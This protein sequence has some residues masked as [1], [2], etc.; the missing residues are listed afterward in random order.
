MSVVKPVHS[1]GRAASILVGSLLILALLEARVSAKPPEADA[2]ARAKARPVL[3]KFQQSPA[4]FIENRG[5][6]EDASIRFA[7]N[8]TGANAGLT[9]QGV[10]FQLFQREWVSSH[11]EP[12]R[13]GEQNLPS[14]LCGSASLREAADH[15]AVRNAV[16]KMKE[17]AICFDGARAV[18]PAGEGKSEQVFHYRRG[19]QAY[20]RENVPSWNAAV[21][22][23]L[24]EGIDLRVTGRRTGVKYEFLVSPGAD[25]RKI[26]LRYEGIEDLKLCEDGSLELKLGEGWRPLV[27][28]A[29]YIYQETAG[30]RKQVPGRFSLAGNR[31]C[32]F[33]IT[34]PLDP[35]LPL[36]IDPELAWSTYL[37]GSGDDGGWAGIAV[38][39]AGN[40]FVTGNTNSSGW[41]SGGYNTTFSG[42]ADAFVVKLSGSGAHLWSTYL[43]GSGDDYGCGIAADGVGNVFVSGTTGSSGWVSGGWDTTY[44]G[45]YCNAFVVK[46]SGSGEHLWSTYLGGGGDFVDFG[47]A[48]D[49]AGNVFV[50]GDTMSSGW[51]SG[52]GDTT[53]NGG[54]DAFVV[55]LSGEGVHLWSTYVGGS[56]ADGGNDIAVDNAG[57]VF[58]TGN[59][60]SSGWVSGGFDTTFH[61]GGSLPMDAYVAKLS[62]SGVHLWSTYLGGS[63]D[64]NGY[65][66][67]TDGA[68]NVFVTGYTMSSGWVS[69]GFDTTLGGSGDAFV[70]KLSESGSHLWSTYLGGSSDETGCGIAVDGAGNAFVT[71]GTRSSDWV[72]GGFDTTL[73]GSVDAFLAKL[74][75]NGAHLWS[76]Y[77]GGSSGDYGYAI[78][79]DGAGNVLVMG[80]TG[81][82][83]WVSGG[84]DTTYNGGQLDAFVAKIIDSG[85]LL[86]GSLRVTIAPPEC[87]AAGAQWRREG[88]T[89]WLD[90][91]YTESG[92]LV[93]N[94][95]V[96]FRDI[97]GWSTPGEMK[98][99]ISDGQTTNAS[100]IYQLFGCSLVWSTYLGGDSYDCGYGIAVDGTGNM[101]V[102]GCT[103][104]SG[105]VS[106]G[107]DTTFNGN[108]DA[109]VVKLSESGSHLWST[110]LGGDAADYGYGIAVDGTGNVFVTGYTNSSGWVSGGF[111]T[112]FN[113]GV[114][115]AFVVK[116]SGSGA[117]L[118][119]TYLGGS[120]EDYGYGIAVDGAGNVFVT[121]RTLSSGW[122]S[123]GFDTTYNGGF[124]DADD[125]DAFVAKL[126]GTGAHLWSTYLGGSDS[127]G[128]NAIA[129]DGAGNVLVTGN[130]SS[131]GWVLGGFDTTLDGTSDA[132][133][134]KLSGS[135]SH[136]WSTYLGG[137][138]YDC[139]Y[140]IAVDGAGN[141]F[142]TGMTNSSGWVSGGFDMTFNG[143]TDAFVAELSGSGEHLWSTYLG[144]SNPDYGNGIAVDGAGNVLVMGGTGSSGWVSGGFDTRLDGGFDAFVAELSGSGSH[145]WST[146]LG[147]ND[148]DW[149]NG[150]AVDSAGNVFVTGYTGSSD[151]VSGGFDTTYNGNSDAFVAKIAVIPDLTPPVILE[152]PL[153]TLITNQSSAIEWRT[154]EPATSFVYYGT[155]TDLGTI[156][157]EPGFASQHRVELTSL[158]ANTLY[159]YKVASSDAAGNGPTES[160]VF[161]F[162]TL[163]SPDLD[164]PEIT[165]G[166]MALDVTD[167]G[168]TILWTTN[169]V[170]TSGVSY[171]D[172]SAYGVVNDD[173]LVIQ[174]SMRL[175]NLT[176]ATL[177]YCTVSSKDAAGNGP[178]FSPEF[179]FTTQAT[180]DTA[181]PIITEGPIVMNVSSR[182][183]TARWITDE[184]ADSVVEYGLTTETLGQRVSRAPLVHQHNV[185]LT[186]L[187]T[188]TLY[189]Y[190]VLSTDVRGNGPT[191]SAV[192]SF[193]T[194]T[195]PDSL[196]P[197]F[198]DGPRVL[199]VNQSSATI[200]WETDEL[201]DTV[202]DYGEGLAL[203][204]RCSDSTKT[205]IHQITLT[206]LTGGQSYSFMASSTDMN[207]NTASSIESI[208]PGGGG[209]EYP[210]PRRAGG[211][212]FTTNL[213]PDVTPPHITE[214][215]TVW[216]VTDRIAVVRW[217]TDEI[218]DTRVWY[219]LSAQGLSHFSG[220]LMH[221][222]EHVVILTGLTPSTPYVFQV[223]SV[224]TTRNGP[225]LS[226]VVEFTT[227]AAPDQTPPVISQGHLAVGD[228]NRARASISWFTNEPATSG[229]IYGTSP[230]E[231]RYTASAEGYGV[232]HSVTV[233]HLAAGTRYYGRAVSS[234]PS[235]NTTI[236][237]LME[238]M[239]PAPLHTGCNPLVW[240]NY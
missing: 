25:W 28:S 33:E 31:V 118:W 198:L 94:H 74:S 134:A 23:G 116:L 147:G 121:G 12:Q 223:G 22:R 66:I 120:D 61:G 49:G 34:G 93:G 129:V 157:S 225:E 233:T 78:A 232:N 99:T 86:T 16:T 87:M 106:G 159:Y 18:A 173:N 88:T 40:V 167:T 138:S 13:R 201:S 160:S 7:M 168:A 153:A 42:G 172:G 196:E 169:E 46:L 165:E 58:V 131:S 171:N 11:A 208:E 1:K 38:D 98:V 146:Y 161:S 136:L 112:T 152:G 59:T 209:A 127:D 83:G 206:G 126:S 142:V 113:S 182:G 139:G 236:S 199:D 105:W 195:I 101:F 47:I 62:A 215:P 130:T 175:T 53:F 150:I 174:H 55:K 80:G 151:W 230:L 176:S 183:G 194:D 135:G 97:P 145:V 133:V 179:T 154:D 211:L 227:Q 166:P 71:G 103:I 114:F 200:Y 155:T 27:D 76:T 190:H 219:G 217:V 102:T 108:Y 96:E 70:V 81:S 123:G 149:G 19:D 84:F 192:H 5:Q 21:Y 188:D 212:S 140:G 177:Y 231:L 73:D 197:V 91:G 216:V 48:V 90:S 51:V 57:N 69:G 60:S 207:G 239:L 124:G 50:S 235:G 8:S 184:S 2:E 220:E 72:S 170:A 202:V 213:E 210:V 240:G 109:F 117:H 204:L 43:G 52:G 234:D 185:S 178:T 111:D 191:S 148:Y 56:D 95:M 228:T 37:G 222:F 10:R 44:N 54:W 122:I 26:R 110:Y 238:F 187:T 24:W 45:G 104:S 30:G 141:V 29:P 107:F 85:P 224:D 144:G 3:E 4:V 214:G 32:A 132:F 35:S 79:V 125:G 6:W 115:D 205:R 181:P 156:A 64:D 92:L 65:G 100:G 89:N 158:T 77:L 164:P 180:P 82:S 119:S 189:Y 67:A 193:R 36:V 17:F 186:N 203:N 15:D 20:W 9:D 128:G 221:K 41:V 137:D 68:G 229:I 163:A 75:G 162:T 226:P 63:N 143:T 39:S 14:S 218:G 237:G